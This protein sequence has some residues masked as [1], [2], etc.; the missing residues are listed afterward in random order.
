VSTRKQG[1]VGEA[2]RSL[3]AARGPGEPLH[4]VLARLLRSRIERGAWPAGTRLPSVRGLADEFGVSP[5]TVSR[6]VRLLTA[7]GTVRAHQGKGVF[8]AER[9]AAPEQRNAP[10]G[11]QSALLPRPAETRL[12]A[13]VPPGGA[14]ADAISLASGGVAS[15]LLNEEAA[16]STW[17]RLL[18][19]THSGVLQ[20]GTEPHRL[21]QGRSPAG[22]LPLRAW[23]AGYLAQAG[24]AADAGQILVTTGAQQAL[25]VVARTLLRPGD[26][27]LVER[28]AY[29]FALAVFEAV[30]AT[31]VEVP[32]DE[33]GIVVEAATRL[34]ASHRPRLLFTVP[35]G[36]APTGATMPPER[37]RALVEAARR[38]GVVVVEEDHAREFTFDGPPP[39]AIKSFDEDGH[40][41]YVRSFGKVTLPSLRIGCI[42]AH[43]PLFA[44]LVE[45]KRLADR[46]TSTL[47]QD[48]FLTFV[49]SGEFTAH[50]ER[51]RALY[52]ARRD[53]MLGA[54]ERHMPRGIGWTVPAAGFNVWLTL[55]AGVS[56]QRVTARAAAN[57]VLVLAGGPFFA[58]RD[59]DSA[60]RLT[61]S[62][63]P[64]DRLDEA[65][66]R[67]AEVVRDSIA[68]SEP[69]RGPA[70][71]VDLVVA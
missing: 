56:A 66:R 8:V 50:L 28:P 55:P 35:T 12:A 45:S 70:A 44:A 48:A 13:L 17:R 59:P 62:D 5:V 41:V 57:G 34:M 52:R 24:I 14:P 3:S 47:T 11:W 23:M 42:A 38:Y 51:A 68:V 19:S 37:R 31:C 20:A 46:Y 33:G 30:G 21:L 49:S 4:S 1:A 25:N 63:N 40:V 71:I 27:I 61:Y 36:H 60:L 2:A 32:V 22:E 64:P 29:V 6:A 26:T 67:L 9:T 65:V 69:T 39:P 58:Q 16:R 53:A 10:Y 7:D 54:L 43:G 18:R 15:D